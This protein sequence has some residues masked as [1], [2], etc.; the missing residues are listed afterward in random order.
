MAKQQ[1]PKDPGEVVRFPAVMTV[2]DRARLRIVAA[3]LG[4]PM[5]DLAG[6]WITEKLAAE[7]SRLGIRPPSKKRA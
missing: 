6:E 3:H 4:R 1:Q 2:G 7:E 5:E